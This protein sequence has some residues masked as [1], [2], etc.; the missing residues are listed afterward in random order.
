M[1]TAFLSPD[2]SRTFLHRVSPQPS[3][4]KGVSVPSSELS[5]AQA[6]IPGAYER[7]TLTHRPVGSMG[8]PAFG[9][10]DVPIGPSSLSAATIADREMEG[11]GG[12]GQRPRR[13]IRQPQASPSV[14]DVEHNESRLTGVHA[15][16]Q[17][18]WRLARR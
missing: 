14:A 16:F 10:S 18:W 17:L 3:I 13:V 12:M 8:G 1:G 15:W 5:Q 7:N 2:P 9:S 4:S 11:G 6:L